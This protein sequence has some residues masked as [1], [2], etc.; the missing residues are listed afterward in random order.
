[1]C[2]PSVEA[3]TNIYI[4]ITMV[5]SFD[6]NFQCLITDDKGYGGI[7]MLNR[8]VQTYPNLIAIRNL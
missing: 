5:E 1:M 8:D 7:G 6:N 4:I 3:E 2:P